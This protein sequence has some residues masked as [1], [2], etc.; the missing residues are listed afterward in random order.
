[1]KK[2]TSYLRQQREKRTLGRGKNIGKSWKHKIKC[3]VWGESTK[4]KVSMGSGQKLG[5]I[6]GFYVGKWHNQIITLK[7]FL[8][9]NS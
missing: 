6:K 5:Q 8:W 9:N 3:L 2:E 7:T 4:I 1:M